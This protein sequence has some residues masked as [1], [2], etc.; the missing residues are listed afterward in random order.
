MS[1]NRFLKPKDN[2]RFNFLADE[3]NDNKSSSYKLNKSN[4]TNF[5]YEPTKNSFTQNFNRDVRNDIRNDR[6][7]DIRENRRDDI[8]ENR[9]N[10]IRNDRRNNRFNYNLQEQIIKPEI[11][12]DVNN[13][14]IFPELVVNKREQEQDKNKD[15]KV[16][17]STNFKDILNNTEETTENINK[18]LPGWIKLSMIN[19]KVVIENG[20]PSPYMVKLKNQEELQSLQE[21]DFH[22]NTCKVIEILE[23][24]YEENKEI[25]D[26]ING[27]GA[28]YERFRLSPVYG[29]EYDTESD[30]YSENNDDSSDYNAEYCEYDYE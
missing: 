10:D 17:L 30:Y 18:N 20:P 7:N 21:N 25:Y 28:Y 19:K 23:K 5:Q 12:V 27:E 13:T 15:S 24:K 3:D 26:S 29:S 6:R 4:K 1:N 2:N 9:R 8:R 11:K 16:V 14:E 22:Y